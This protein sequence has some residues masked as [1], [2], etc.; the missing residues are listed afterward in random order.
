MSLGGK[1]GELMTVQVLQLALDHKAAAQV[2]ESIAERLL[3]LEKLRED[4][5]DEDT[6]AD[7]RNDALALRPLY[8]ELRHRAVQTYGRSILAISAAISEIDALYAENC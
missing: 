1:S 8:E 3:R 5:V 7:A 2:L 4:E 6:F